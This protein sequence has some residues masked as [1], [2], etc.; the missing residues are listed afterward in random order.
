MICLAEPNLLAFPRKPN[1]KW[2][3][4][5]EKSPLGPPQPPSTVTEDAFQRRLER[6]GEDKRFDRETYY[7]T[8]VNP[9]TKVARKRIFPR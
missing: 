6:L 2:L 9:K 5:I 4:K 8:F 1:L 3:D 7:N